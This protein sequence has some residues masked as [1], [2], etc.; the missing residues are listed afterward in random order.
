MSLLPRYDLGLDDLPASASAWGQRDRAVSSRSPRLETRARCPQA[1]AR[2]RP[3]D[4]AA[5]RT[6]S[7]PPK[8]SRTGEP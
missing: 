5:S 4:G 2:C 8:T 7:T 3:S 6:S 1:G